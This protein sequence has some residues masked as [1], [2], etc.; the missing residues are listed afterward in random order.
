YKQVAA[1]RI[2]GTEP[3]PLIEDL[4][5]TFGDLRFNIDLKHPG[6][7]EPL[8]RVLK[9]T[10]AWN[11]VCVTSF[12][13]RRLR[14]A[15]AI[16]NRHVCFAV[17]LGPAA[18]LRYAGSPGHMAARIARAGVQC[19]QIPSWIA[20]RPFIHRAQTAGMHVHVSTVNTKDQ[21]ERVLDLNADGIMT[22][23]IE[24]LRDV[25]IG[26]GQWHPR[27]GSDASQP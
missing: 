20:T 21:M 9:R 8:A 22:D 7:I 5:G 19:A 15:Q 10:A 18:T 23:Y 25:L 2:G 1:A 26:R 16:M 13:G 27:V 12:S 24:T 6:T 14:R 4:L 3:I 17:T 11:R